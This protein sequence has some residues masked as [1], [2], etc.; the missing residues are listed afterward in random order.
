MTLDRRPLALVALAV[1]ACGC[2]E[3][4][5]PLSPPGQVPLDS[6]LV[7]VWRCA[8]DPNPHDEHSTLRVLPY[9]EFQYYGEWTDEDGVTRFRAY[10]SRAGA[11]V[12][13]NLRPLQESRTPAKWMLLRYRLEGDARLRLATVAEHSVKGL[14]EDEALKRIRQRVLE[15]SLYDDG[16]L[17][18]REQSG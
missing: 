14:K 15:E 10:G 5:A 9:D 2:Y 13:L 17:C 4:T 11:S 7:G 6:A 18:T 12:L 16:S 8:P 1:C 3:S